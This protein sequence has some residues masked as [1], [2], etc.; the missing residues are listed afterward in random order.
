MAFYNNGFIPGM[1]ANILLAQIEENYNP[2]SENAQS[3]KAVAE[4][5]LPINTE[6]NAFYDKFASRE[7]LESEYVAK[8]NIKT[9]NGE[10]L[11]G[12]GDITIKGGGADDKYELIE[13]V[14]ITEEETVA[15]TR[16]AEP[17]GTPYS[18]K[19]V[20]I[21]VQ[22][23]N[24]KGDNTSIQLM[25]KTTEGS[26]NFFAATAKTSTA[27][28]YTFIRTLRVYNHI[29]CLF[30]A[31]TSNLGIGSNL[32]MPIGYLETEK[33]IDELT[34]KFTTFPIGA[35]IEIWGVRA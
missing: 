32:S 29:L 22:W 18:F 19:D 4:A 1:Q 15:I 12:S 17:D 7:F 34:L 20:F 9:V 33:P 11:V 8:G 30:P 25:V 23:N 27:S 2:D 6:L 24:I 35:V 10:S 3:G 16:N 31:T 13:T 26:K 5:L 28:G 14:N 21:S